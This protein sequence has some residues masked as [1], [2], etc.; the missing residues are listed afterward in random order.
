MAS[1]AN[2]G[3]RINLLAELIAGLWFPGNVNAVNFFKVRFV[4]QPSFMRSQL[5]SVVR[6]HHHCSNAVVCSRSKIGTLCPYCTASDLLGAN[7]C[8]LGFKLCLCRH[9]ELPDDAD[10]RCVFS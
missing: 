3:I 7:H 9:L 6:C 2:V 10:Q 5:F 4:Q 8:D 1:T